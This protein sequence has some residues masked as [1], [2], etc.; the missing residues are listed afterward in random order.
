MLMMTDRAATLT[1]ADVLELRASVAERA[2][3]CIHAPQGLLPFKFPTPTYA[4]QAGVDD[5]ARVPARST[6]GFYPQLYDWDGLFFSEAMGRLL[7]DPELLLAVVKNFLAHQGADGFVPRTI[8]PNKIWDSGDVCKPFMAQM[9][10]AALARG[11]IFTTDLA[12][13]IEPIEKLLNY[14]RRHRWHE[15]SGLYHWRNVLE[16]GVDN[17]PALLSPREAHESENAHGKREVNYPDG[18]LLAADLNA[19][20]FAE[21]LA[22]GRICASCGDQARAKHYAQLALELQTRIETTLWD[23]RIGMYVNVDP[24][25]GDSVQLRSWTGL[26]PALFGVSN[27]DRTRQVIEENILSERHFL[28]PCGIASVAAS[29]HLHHQAPR[30]LYGRAYV[31][32]WSGPVWILPNVLVSRLLVSLDYVREARDLAGRVLNAVLGD[33]RT[34]K[35]MHENY[36]CDTGRPLWAPRFMSWNVGAID[37]SFVLDST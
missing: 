2:R 31:C 6:D 30:G 20:M 29:E 27:S 23:E 16:S 1:H 9:L 10:M 24:L 25:T 7:G 17:N 37:L 22:F 12:P 19:Y 28:R 18:Y 3:A 21:L 15:P 4:I 33:L 5:G 26:T 13:L 36:D 32:N 34:N 35:M 8:S 11:D 14:Y